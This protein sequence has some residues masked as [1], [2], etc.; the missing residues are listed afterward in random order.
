MYMNEALTFHKYL[1]ECDKRILRSYQIL[2][3]GLHTQV[4]VETFFFFVL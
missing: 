3:V 2:T 4:H 1:Q